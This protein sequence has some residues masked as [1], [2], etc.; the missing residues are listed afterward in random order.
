MPIQTALKLLI[1]RRVTLVLF[2]ETNHTPHGTSLWQPC[3]S[4]LLVVQLIEV[5]IKHQTDPVSIILFLLHY[6]VATTKNGLVKFYGDHRIKPHTSL[7]VRLHANSFE[8]Q[9]CDRTPQMINLTR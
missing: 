5:E 4:T 9:P 1:A 8:F 6:I 3:K 2:V 7:F